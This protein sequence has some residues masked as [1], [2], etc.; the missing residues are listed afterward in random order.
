MGT[1]II[2]NLHPGSPA[3]KAQ[4]CSSFFSRLKGLMFRKSLLPDEAILL[5]ETS[6]SRMNASIH[7]FFMNFDIAVVWINSK[8]IVVDRVIARKW[9]PYYAPSGPARFILEIHP[10]RLNSFKIGDQVTFTHD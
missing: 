5:V 4:Y 10:D 2:Q 6:D 3:L 8:M 9:K 7:M 1:V